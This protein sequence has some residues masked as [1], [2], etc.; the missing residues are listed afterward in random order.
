M[1]Q[2]K[3]YLAAEDFNQFDVLATTMGLTR[4]ELA[5][6][7]IK[8]FIYSN[9][10]A[11][12]Q[13]AEQHDGPSLATVIEPTGEDTQEDGEDFLVGE[14]EP[15]REFEYFT[16]P[17]GKRENL[18]DSK[19]TLNDSDPPLSGTE[20]IMINGRKRWSGRRRATRTS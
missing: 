15:P 18:K 5:Q 19:K 13:A 14:M 6:T 10:K 11:A 16:K 20:N 9:S 4:Y 7:A 17:S 1:S 2:I 12:E 8:K 3:T